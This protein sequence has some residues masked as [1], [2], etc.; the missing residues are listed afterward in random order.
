MKILPILCG[1]FARSLYEGGDPEDDDGVK[2]FLDALGELREREG[3]RL[4]WVLGVDMAHMGA[5]YG[6][7]FAAV[8][9]EGAMQEVGARD[10]QRIERIN[11]L[12]CRR[13]LGP[14]ARESATI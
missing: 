6:D 12:R 8:A 5:R 1:P 7:R 3:D 2:R 13:L 14:G 4:F 10:E 9:G 11:A